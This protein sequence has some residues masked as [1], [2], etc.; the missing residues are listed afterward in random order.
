[1][2]HPGRVLDVGEVPPASMVAYVARQIGTDPAA[3]RSKPTRVQTRREQIAELMRHHGF[4]AFGRADAARLLSWLTP[5]AQLNRKPGDLIAMLVEEV[6]R[7]R[8]LLPTP[9]VL[10]LIVHHART[11]GERITH[12]AL[13]IDLTAAQSA[14]LD[15]QLESSGGPTRM[16]WLRQT[17]S[18]PASR[19]LLGLLERVRTVR[20]LGIERNQ[21]N[22]APT[23][24]FDAL[25]GEGLRMTA[26][27]L[28]DLV[29]LRRAATMTAA[30]I[31]PETELADAALL[32]FDKLMG[33]WPGS[34]NA[35]RWNRPLGRCATP[36]A[37]SAFWH[38]QAAR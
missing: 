13:T 12:R 7:Q 25:A 32:M 19:N 2:R 37:T 21:E 8:V 9:R 27:H 30:V 22:A 15:G 10:E 14:A 16:A 1:M 31:Q 38:V 5:I 36:R 29:Q 23:P 33:V 18:F 20:T 34:R 11:R 26:Q 4:G 6:R 24:A 17:S 3:L 28:R 35:K